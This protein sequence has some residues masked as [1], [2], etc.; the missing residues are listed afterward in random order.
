M[1][2]PTSAPDAVRCPRWVKIVLATS[3]ALN[4]LIAGAVVGFALREGPNRDGRSAMGYAT[5]YVA[6]LP[7]EA[8]R[9]VFRAIR[10]DEALPRRSA[11]RAQYAE[12]MAALRA[13]PFELDLV[14][15][16]LT[17]QAQS[18]DRFQ[19]VAQSAWLEAVQGMSAQERLTY[20]EEV[21]EVLS[22]GPGRED[23]DRK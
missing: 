5:P 21:E 11:R 9:G 8:R 7:R 19:G 20:A 15:A 13:D 14:Q 10:S 23:R 18:V 22:R 2:D 16:I 17:R 1:T 4:L 3:L 6:A 12:M